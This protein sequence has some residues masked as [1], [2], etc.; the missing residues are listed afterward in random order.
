[1]ENLCF[2]VR[3]NIKFLS[4]LGWQPRRIIESLQQVSGS[5]ASSESVV[6]EWIRRFK[7]GREAIE[8][9]RRNRGPCPEP[10]G[11]RPQGSLGLSVPAEGRLGQSCNHALFKWTGGP[12]ALF[13]VAG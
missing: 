7:E 13:P 6:Y 5:S 3:A 8:D 2:E 9:D 12:C 10:S 1:M 11:R 4:K